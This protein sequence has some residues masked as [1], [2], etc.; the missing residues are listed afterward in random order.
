MTVRE[1]ARLIYMI[2]ALGFLTGC[3]TVQTFETSS[4]IITDDKAVVKVC[5]TSSGG[6]DRLKDKFR[7]SS[8][9]RSIVISP[10]SRSEGGGCAI[11]GDDFLVG[12]QITIIEEKITEFGVAKIE[13]KPENRLVGTPDL[14]NGSV[15]LDVGTGVTEVIFS[16]QRLTG[17]IEV[18]V[19]GSEDKYVR[20]RFGDTKELKGGECSSA[21]LTNA[22]MLYVQ[23]T[24]APEVKDCYSLLDDREVSCEIPPNPGAG[25]KAISAYIAP[26][27]ISNQTIAIIELED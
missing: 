13:V 24:Y 2:P 10:A 12:S 16:N 6:V 14:T 26:G 3:S 8:E 5:K 15:D 18:C 22:G 1:V 20:L 4:R 17:F 25:A 23:I 27:D 9:G 11:L 21:F 19:K 7:F